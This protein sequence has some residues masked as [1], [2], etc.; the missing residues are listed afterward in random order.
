MDA[1]YD[2]ERHEPL[3]RHRGTRRGCATR[4]PRSAATPR[5]RS[6]PHACGRCIRATRGPESP[7]GSCAASTSAPPGCSTAS[8]A[9]GSRAARARPI[10][11]AHGG[12]AARGV[13]SASPDEDG[14]GA[15]LLVGSSG[16]LLVAHRLAPSAGDADALATRSPRTSSTRRTSCCSARPARCSRPARCTPARRG[17]VRRAVARERPHAARPPGA[18]TACGRR[19]ST[20]TGVRYIGA[21]ARLRRQRAGAARRAGVARRCAGGR[22][23]RRRDR[24]RT[25]GRRRRPGELAAL[26]AARAE[27]PPRVQWCHGAP[28]IVTSLAALAPGD[29]RA[30]RAAARPAASSSGT[31]GP[32]RRERRP[33]PRHGRQ[34][35]RVPARC[36]SAPATSAGSRGRARSR[37]TPSTRSTR[38][39]AADGR[40]RYTLFTGD[41]GA[42]LLRR[43]LPARATLAF[44]GLDDW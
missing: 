5:R 28:G 16:I 6:T 20:A 32:L 24:A 22:G 15:S 7:T 41:I 21:G 35:L 23:A 31:P 30:R 17:A 18:P 44:P 42:A 8:A 19:T 13:R 40:G 3:A 2:P 9:R 27:A 4:S 12:G 43:G 29:E 25:R 14:A 39:R 33:V 26:G 34:R 11:A 37:C 1:L 10:D 36:S 38:L